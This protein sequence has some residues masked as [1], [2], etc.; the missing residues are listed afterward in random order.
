M[1][2]SLSDKQKELIF[3]KMFAFVNEPYSLDFMKQENWF[4]LR[5]WNQ[6]AETLFK[7][8]LVKYFQQNLE[9]R[10]SLATKAADWF[11][12]NYGWKIKE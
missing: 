12:L 9:M 10:K 11:M 6:D 5:T 7:N 2:V 3:T 1:A 4:Q 8:W